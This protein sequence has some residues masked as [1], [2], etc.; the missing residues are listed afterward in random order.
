MRKSFVNVIAM[1]FITILYFICI[2]GKAQARE[3]A[4]DVGKIDSVY[5]YHLV[6]ISRHLED[7]QRDSTHR[8]IRSVDYLVK[9]TGISS[10]EEWTYFGR[11]GLRKEDVGKWKRWYDENRHLL[12]WDQKEKMIKIVRSR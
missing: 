10:S 2:A 3:S 7:R 4:T 6:V 9:I 5:R 12:V 8:W 1:I 11:M